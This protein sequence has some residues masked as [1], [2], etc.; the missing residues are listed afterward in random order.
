MPLPLFLGIAAA[1]AGTAGIGL[2]IRG[3][4]NMKQANDTLKEAQKRND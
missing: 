4:V 3:G 1:V 2:G